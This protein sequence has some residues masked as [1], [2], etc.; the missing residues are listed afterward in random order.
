MR[1]APVVVAALVLLGLALVV[2][3][4]W[5]PA[6]RA[7]ATHVG[8]VECG[9]SDDH[10]DEGAISPG[11]YGESYFDDATKVLIYF[12]C[13]ESPR[14]LHFGVVSPWTGWV[15]V[16]LQARD[17]WNGALNEV[18]VSYAHGLGHPQAVDGYRQSASA[19]I[20]LDASLGGSFDVLNLTAEATEVGRVYEFCVPL[21]SNDTYDNQLSSQGPFYF[22]IEYNASSPDPGSEPTVTSEPLAIF[23]GGQQAA[24]TTTFLD[25]SMSPEVNILEDAAMLVSVRDAAGYPIPGLGIQVFVRTAFGF[26]T[27]GPVVTNDQGVAQVSYA[28]R[29]NGS[30]FVGAAYPGGSGLLASVAWRLLTVL[31]LD[32]GGD[33]GWGSVRPVEAI[34]AVVVASVW[35]SYAYAF[36]IT[37]QAQRVEG[38]GSSLLSPSRSSRR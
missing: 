6:P 36:F 10:H 31:A 12:S 3:N 18:R 13:D 4:P 1:L 30:Y 9:H 21:Q 24:G 29:D 15:G 5:S 7:R 26:L 32:P 20:A 2:P 25:L 37:W 23:L 17:L 28:A 27:L 16:L 35:V 11:E 14:T 34:I 33:D 8:E 22:A 38:A 19:P